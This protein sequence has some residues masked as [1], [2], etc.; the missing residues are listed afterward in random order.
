MVSEIGLM[1]G[2]VEQPLI[3]FIG[4]VAALKKQRRA[5]RTKLMV[6]AFS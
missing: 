3:T 4:M 5:R 1:N 2:I 6:S